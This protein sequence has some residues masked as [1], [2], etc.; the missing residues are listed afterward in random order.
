MGRYPDSS[1]TLRPTPDGTNWDSGNPTDYSDDTERKSRVT[2]GHHFISSRGAR[3]TL[4]RFLKP[5]LRDVKSLQ[6]R[7]KES[8]QDTFI[9][10]LRHA[11]LH[12][13]DRDTQA[14]SVSNDGKKPRHIDPTT[15]VRELEQPLD[16]M[17][18]LVEHLFTLIDDFDKFTDTDILLWPSES[19]SERGRHARF[20]LLPH[21]KKG[22]GIGADTE[23]I[24]ELAPIYEHLF[25]RPF[26]VLDSSRREDLRRKRNESDDETA[27]YEGPSVRF[28]CAVIKR[29][30]LQN[31]F[32]PPT[33]EGLSQEP[34]H[35]LSK[36]ETSAVK[37]D[38]ASMNRHQGLQ[39][40]NV[41]DLRLINR[42]GDIWDAEKNRKTSS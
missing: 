16:A 4:D 3:S 24:R 30:G 26:A 41:S 9:E 12:L 6:A 36:E 10:P 38:V 22:G 27:R 13:L 21:L 11:S 14:W 40:R 28:A 35:G 25:G 32:V 17:A 33:S 34:D 15:L 5:L 39:G 29:F 37:R 18:N 42:I 19:E 7:L 23:F 2:A 1:T 31:L 20:Q 8:E